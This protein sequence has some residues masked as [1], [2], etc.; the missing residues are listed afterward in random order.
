[1]SQTQTRVSLFSLKVSKSNNVAMKANMQKAAIETLAELRREALNK[2]FGLDGSF[3]GPGGGSEVR[4]VSRLM[5]TTFGRWCFTLMALS[6][7]LVVQIHRMMGLE[8]QLT[9]AQSEVLDMGKAMT[10]VQMW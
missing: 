4:G 2:A 1:M 10:K 6:I 7:L 9:Q 5:E 8:Q 3:K